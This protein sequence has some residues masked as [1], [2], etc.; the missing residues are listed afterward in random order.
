EDVLQVL[1]NHPAMALREKHF[2]S[3]KANWLDKTQNIQEIS[4]EINISIDH[5][6]FVDDNPVEIEKVKLRLPGITCLQI[7]S[8][9]LNFVR[10]FEELGALQKMY[11]TEEDRLRGEQYFDDRQRREF[12]ETAGSIDAFYRSLSQ[13]MTIH[14]N[15]SGH[16]SRIAQLTQ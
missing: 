10:Q 2:A 1:R 11:V 15:Y 13:G 5:M 7:E 4:K 14:S 3:I 9:P 16:V 8:P 12:K 6:L